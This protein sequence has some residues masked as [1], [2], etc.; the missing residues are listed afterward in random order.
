M[1]KIL[2]FS[3]RLM[4]TCMTG[5]KLLGTV[6]ACLMELSETKCSHCTV[7]W[8]L[9]PWVNLCSLINSAKNSLGDLWELYN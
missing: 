7:Q 2:D 8:L 3:G 9:S 5:G 4:V 6:R 1:V